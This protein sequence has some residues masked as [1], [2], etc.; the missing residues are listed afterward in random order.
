M[1]DKIN[2]EQSNEAHVSPSEL[3]DGLGG[4]FNRTRP[5]YVLKPGY[6]FSRTD[7]DRHFI[8]AAQLVRLYRVP[9]CDCVVEPDM[10]DPRNRHWHPPHGAIYL[11]PQFDGDYTLT[12]NVK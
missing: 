12:P 4:N 2:T 11:T 1:S 3:D 6:I 10:D 8:S 9:M 7:R 5:K